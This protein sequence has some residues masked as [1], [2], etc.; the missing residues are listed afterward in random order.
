MVGQ[1]RAPGVKHRGDADAGAEVPGI[2]R[3]G[4]HGLGRSR[5]QD[6]VDRGLVLVGDVGDGGR[7]REHHME[8]RH[9]K[10]VG[11]AGGE[12]L[13]CSSALTLGA[14]PV[15]AAIVGDDGVSALLVIAA[16]HMAA[17]RRRAAAL[18]G[19]HH[20]HLV[21]AD[22]TDVGAPPRRS[23]VAEDIRDLKG[24]TGHGAVTPAAGL[25]GPSWASCAA[26]TAGRG[27]S[28]CRRSCRWRRAC[29]APSCPICRDQAAPG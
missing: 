14:V 7:Q 6:V 25:C 10:Q 17:E 29:S 8:I 13:A 9:R 27:G 5:E 2:G 20:L 12:P 19:A 22:V 26:A 28:R 24:R 11:L 3:D 18:D 1:R 23:V 15:T 4:G 16:R 21:E